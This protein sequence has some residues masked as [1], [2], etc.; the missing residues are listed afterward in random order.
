MLV[1]GDELGRTQRGN[2]NAYCQDNEISWFDWDLTEEQRALSEFTARLVGIFRAHPV[3]HRRRFLQGRRIRGSTIKDLTWYGP[4]GTEMSDEEWGAVGV[5]TVGLR[6]AGSAISEPDEHGR[7]IVDD[8]LLMV[9]NEDES[10]IDFR[11]P[12]D[13]GHVWEL[14]I[15]TT[16]AVIPPDPDG[17]PR[18]GGSVCRVEPR[19][20]LL[21][22]QQPI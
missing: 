13:H 21:L 5:R 9:L 4:A 16:T 3:L 12:A 1:G 2:N 8:T 15:D 7:H 22:R 19:S 6:L 20:F 17:H 11:L 14:L 18:P 10:P